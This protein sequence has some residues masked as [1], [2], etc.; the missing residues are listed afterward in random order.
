MHL[1][2]YTHIRTQNAVVNA[3]L[4]RVGQAV[5]AQHSLWALGA[6]VSVDEVLREVSPEEVGG[7]FRLLGG[8]IWLVGWLVG[9]VGKSCPLSHHHLNDDPPSAPTQVCLYE[10]M[11]AGVR[12]LLDEGI[13]LVGKVGSFDASRIQPIL[14]SNLQSLLRDRQ[15][16]CVANRL[17]A[18]GCLYIYICMHICASEHRH[19]SPP[20]ITSLTNNL[21][22]K[23]KHTQLQRRADAPRRGHRT[24]HAAGRGGGG[25]RGADEGE[26][27]VL[28]VGAGILWGGL[29]DCGWD[30]LRPSLTL[31]VYAPHGSPDPLPPKHPNTQIQS[32]RPC[33]RRCGRS[34]R[35][36]PSSSTRCS[37]RPGPSPSST[38]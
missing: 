21:H 34:S 23:P 38:T 20:V 11:C 9:W 3:N 6:G 24:G 16:R 15:A 2:I 14:A 28:L 19:L 7:S 22:T 12:R 8:L 10:S 1:Y 36:A 31:M 17:S 26:F 5:D 27:S 35:W 32:T 29:D 30:G 25:G 13:N 4:R 33:T 37:S 18:W